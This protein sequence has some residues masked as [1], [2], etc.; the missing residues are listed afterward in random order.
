MDQLLVKYAN[1]Q[2][3]GYRSPISTNI[4]KEK[5]RPVALTVQFLEFRVR[6]SPPLDVHPSSV[7]K[8]PIQRQAEIMHE[9]RAA[10][11][12]MLL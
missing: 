3:Q 4:L 10:F 11:V 7:E 8:N 6:P 12:R 1:I 2:V 5:V 9:Q